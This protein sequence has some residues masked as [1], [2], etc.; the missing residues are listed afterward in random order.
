MNSNTIEQLR[1]SIDEANNLR[2]EW[3]SKLQL[4]EN[5]SE[6]ERCKKEIAHLKELI[7]GYEDE[8][9]SLKKEPTPLYPD[10]RKEWEEETLNE[11][12]PI[13]NQ[14][15]YAKLIEMVFVKGGEF[16]MG[17]NH[18]YLGEPGKQIIVKDFF[19]GKYPITQ[20]QWTALM[21]DNPS[22][23]QGDEQ[24]PV[25]KVCWEDALGF[26]EKLN[27]LSKKIYR[28][29]TEEEWEYAARG[30]QQSKTY[31]YAG[32]NDINEV[33]WYEKNSKQKTH[34]VGQKKTN[35]LGIYDMS[36]NV[37]EWCDSHHPSNPLLKATRGG[38]WKHKD[39]QISTPDYVSK[40]DSPT[41][42]D[43]FRLVITI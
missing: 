36:G 21:G 15:N 25:E 1:K 42:F 20:A 18:G 7:K 43:G 27:Y 3:E 34:P 22:H 14:P 24:C 9:R 30:G 4:A 31:L 5:P 8:I 37:C 32:S 16:R 33:A 17:N 29:P 12:E 38:S 11:N 23:F 41:N 35:E 26:I 6:K 19:I 10:S 40:N 13:T 28:L 2:W 39:C